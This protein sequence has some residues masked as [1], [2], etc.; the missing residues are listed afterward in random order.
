[1]MSVFPKKKYTPVSGIWAPMPCRGQSHV[2]ES[3]LK[4]KER[5]IDK[6]GKLARYTK[7]GMEFIDG[8]G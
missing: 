3:N 2:R 8:M 4:K 5:K 7:K 6:G 1:M